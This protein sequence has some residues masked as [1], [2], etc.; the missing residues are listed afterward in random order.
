MEKSPFSCLPW[1]PFMSLK[2]VSTQSSLASVTQPS[3]F[4]FFL[5]NHVFQ[6]SDLFPLSLFWTLSSRPFSVLYATFF[7]STFYTIRSCSL[8]MV[9][10]ICFLHCEPARKQHNGSQ[11]QQLNLIWIILSFFLDKTQNNEVNEPL[12][13]PSF[14]VGSYCCIKLPSEKCLEISV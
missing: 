8:Q 3:L 1:Q 12:V 5:I 10:G 9:A 7:S 13:S 11:T 14:P 6:S 2:A 4:Q